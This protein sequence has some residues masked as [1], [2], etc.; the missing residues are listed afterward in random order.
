MRITHSVDISRRPEDV[1]PWIGSPEK[2]MVWMSSVSKR[3]FVHR[4]PEVIGTTFREIV[5]DDGGATEL[6]GVVTG[7]RPNR[8]ISFHLSG[9]YNDVDVEYRLE[10]KGN[11]T[12][13]TQKA[14]IRFKSFL[15]VIGILMRPMIRKKL[16]LQAGRE[17]AALKALCEGGA[18][19]EAGG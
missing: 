6:H 9:H 1:F 7:Y 16:A 4:T 12:R 2:A 8:F 15:R 17:F 10:E 3:E 19:T 13:V 5:S 11:G 18:V 14:D